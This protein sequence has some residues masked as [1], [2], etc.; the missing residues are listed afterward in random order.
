MY[1]DL[2]TH[3]FFSDGVLIPSELVVRA[4]AA[5]YSVIAITD[6]VDYTNMDLVLPRIKRVAAELSRHY[7]IKVIA[8][9][10]ITYV[11]P[12]L[13]QR[14]VRDA[15]KLG[16]RIVVI[17]GETPVEPV[18][19]G[20]NIAGIIAGADILAHP[21][22]ITDK[23]V[24]LAAKNNVRLEITTRVGHLGANVHVAKLSGKFNA[25][26][27]LNT[28]AHAPNELFTDELI[29]KTLKKAGIARPDYEAMK[30]NSIVLA[31]A[32]TAK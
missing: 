29:D 17:H 7:E 24:K 31:N 32:A 5:G 12:A 11:P 3:S 13:I 30:K 1:I 18:P 15:R 2:H 21:G 4:K 6:H 28:D 9:C 8:G 10:E 14:A 23:E 22:F 27:V 20:T 25:K 26:M 16:A 19:K